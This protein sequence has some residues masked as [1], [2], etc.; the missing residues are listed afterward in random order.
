RP[1]AC[2]D[3]RWAGV[4]RCVVSTLLFHASSP[5]VV[6]LS[7]AA[8]VGAAEGVVHVL[9]RVFRQCALAAVFSS[10]ASMPALAAA[11]T[12][13]LDG[14]VVTASRTEQARKQTLAAMT[15]VDRA[16]IER[17]QPNSV[18]DLL[19][20]LPSLSIANHGGP[21]KTTSVF[22]RGTGSGHVLVLVDGVR[23]G[24]VTSGGAAIQDIPVDQ[25]Q[26]IEI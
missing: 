4:R 13:S 3:M 26:R 7:G 9:F 2:P 12:A 21:G 25:I 19:R 11:S 15:V 16:E 23:V 10:A 8:R 18:A 14:M 24:S 6:T 17:L 1:Q 22:L 5:L 20:G